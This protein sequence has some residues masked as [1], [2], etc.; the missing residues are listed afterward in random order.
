MNVIDYGAG[1]TSI[2]CPRRSAGTSWASRVNVQM[3]RSP[4]RSVI[5]SRFPKRNASSPTLNCTVRRSAS[6][7]AVEIAK[8]QDFPSE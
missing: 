5:L 1:G 3:C 6:T 8:R 2:F 4:R 7:G